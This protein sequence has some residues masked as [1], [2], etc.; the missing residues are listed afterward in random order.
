MNNSIWFGIIVVGSIATGFGAG[1]APAPDSDT[2]SA[3]AAM[4]LL[5]GGLGACLIGLTGITGCMGWIP[6]LARKDDP[7]AS[8]PGMRSGIK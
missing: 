5:T 7:A 3:L 8:R 4:L 2:G 6:G 1:A